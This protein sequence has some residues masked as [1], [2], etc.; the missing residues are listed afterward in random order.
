MQAKEN[1]KILNNQTAL[2]HEYQNLQNQLKEMGNEAESPQMSQTREKIFEI[3]NQLRASLHSI[4]AI[5]A[6]LK[7]IILLFNA[8]IIPIIILFIGFI[9]L[10]MRKKTPIEE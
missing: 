9:Y 3:R 4:S 1:E 6:K 5:Y 2:L 7:S 8:V 10:F